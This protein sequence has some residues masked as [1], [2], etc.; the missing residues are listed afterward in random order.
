MEWC[1]L[2]TW[3]KK[4]HRGRKSIIAVAL[5][6][7]APL[8]FTQ[9]GTYSVY[10]LLVN[11]YALCHLVAQMCASTQLLN[12]LRHLWK[13][14]IKCEQF[15]NVPLQE[16]KFSPSVRKQ[17]AYCAQTSSATKQNTGFYL[18]VEFRKTLNSSGW[19]FT[20]MLH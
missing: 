2:Q 10:L 16:N 8:H 19:H 1:H 11:S 13:G 18:A 9:A 20:K 15:A 6:A 3:G 12:F 7:F 5:P 4:N 14:N 17:T